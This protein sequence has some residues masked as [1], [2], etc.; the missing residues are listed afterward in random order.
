MTDRVAV[1]QMVSGPDVPHNLETAARL[2]ARAAREGAALVSL[3]ENFAVLDGG[4]LTEFAEAEGEAGGLQ[5]SFRIGAHSRDHSG[6]RHHPA[7]YPS[8]RQ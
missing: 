3:P 8:R 2:I 5:Q 7:P 6:G 4:P 1:I